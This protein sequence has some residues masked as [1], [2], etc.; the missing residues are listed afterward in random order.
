MKNKFNVVSCQF[1]VHYMFESEQKLS[2]FCSNINETL[3]TDGYFF[4]TC[5]DGDLVKD[6]LINSTHNKIEGKIDDNTVWMIETDY[7]ENENKVSIGDKISVFVESIG[8]NHTEY[9]VSIDLLKTY[10]AE[11]N[12]LLL[13][14]EDSQ[15]LI[16]SDKSF[17][18]FRSWHKKY[19]NSTSGNPKIK[20]DDNLKEYSFMNMWFVFKKYTT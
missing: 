7:F 6:K 19:M 12:I 9:L 4:G 10:L 3:E 14:K 5:L 16:H 11:Y 8:V 18:N 1:A 13:N 15:K 2:D 20:L 17:G